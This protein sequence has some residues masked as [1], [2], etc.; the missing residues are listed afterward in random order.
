MTPKELEKLLNVL[1]VMKEHE[2]AAAE[3]YRACSQI[4]LVDKEFWI[5]MEQEEIKHAQ[6]INRMMKV[7]LERPECFELGHLSK[8]AAVQTSI[9]GI[10]WNIDRL[11]SKEISKSR[12]LFIARDIEQ[13]M[14]ESKYGEIAKT[15]DSE[16]QSLVKEILSD[17]A[18][19]QDRLSKRI[20]EHTAK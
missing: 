7:L 15:N 3:L 13:T 8:L 16:F 12:M 19:H 6:N 20:K 4:W 5:E 2:L 18:A 9:A 10:K 11:K 17:T 1:K 14:I